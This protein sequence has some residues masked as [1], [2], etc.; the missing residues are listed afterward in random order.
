MRTLAT[1]PSAPDRVVAGTN[2]GRPL[3]CEGEGWKQ[4]TVLPAEVGAL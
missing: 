1:H 3:A 4:I 2:A